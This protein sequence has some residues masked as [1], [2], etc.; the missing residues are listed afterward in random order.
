MISL[1]VSSVVL[2]QQLCIHVLIVLVECGFNNLGLIRCWVPDSLQLSFL[3][4]G[5]HCCFWK[6]SI[7]C[8][9]TEFII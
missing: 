1:D 7:F 6:T 4:E 3:P 5:M 2:V 8:Y 9:F